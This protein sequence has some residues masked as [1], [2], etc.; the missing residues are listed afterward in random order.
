MQFDL[1]RLDIY[2]KVPKDLTQPTLTG[3]IGGIRQIHEDR[4]IEKREIV[5]SMWKWK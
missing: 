4:A 2:R 1:R 5:S 3:E